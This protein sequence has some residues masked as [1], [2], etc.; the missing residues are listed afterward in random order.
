MMKT[1]NKIETQGIGQIGCRMSW[2]M[3][4]LMF[5]IAEGN[6]TQTFWGTTGNGR[7]TLLVDLRNSATEN[8]V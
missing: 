7:N 5:L 3:Q 8:E 1:K 4:K 6:C 2:E